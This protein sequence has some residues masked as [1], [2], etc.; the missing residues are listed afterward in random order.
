MTVITL[1][2]AA[3]AIATIAS[4]LSTHTQAA[5]GRTPGTHSVSP[6][7]AATYQIPLWL[8]PGAGGVQ[9]SLTIAYDSQ[10]GGGIVGPGWSLTGLSAITRCNKTFAQ[11]PLPS[12]V[13]LTYDD[14]F[15]LDGQRLRLTSGG[16]LGSYGQP[17]T[18]YDTE[19]ATFSLVTALGASGNGPE[20]FEVRGKNG[21]TYEFGNSADSR[22]TPS[23]S[24]ATIYMWLVNRVE[25]RFGNSYVVTYGTGAAGSAGIG[26]P[27][28]ISYSPTSAGASTHINSVIFEYGPKAG[29]VPGTTDPAIVGYVDGTQI[30]NTNLLLAVNANSNG[31][32]M[33]RYVMAY[34]AA[35]ATTRARLASVTECAGAGGSD[36]LAPTTVTYHNGASG[37]AASSPLALS[38]HRVIGR[39]DIN[40][41]GREDLILEELQ[42]GTSVPINL[43]VAF[44]TSTGFTSPITV[45]PTRPWTTA[46]GDFTGR[47]TNDFVVVDNGNIRYSWNG[48]QF[49][50]SSI[51]L[52]TGNHNYGV[53]IADVTGDGRDDLLFDYQPVKNGS[54]FTSLYASTSTSGGV[55]FDAPIPFGNGAGGVTG[56]MN[57]QS[58]MLDFDG[59]GREDWLRMWTT[60]NPFRRFVA[61]V[62]SRTT[63][64]ESSGSKEIAGLGYI[65]GYAR[66]NDD[67]CTDVIA[68]QA[69]Y[70]S[71]CNG[72]EPFTVGI[73]GTAR[74]AVDWNS[75]GRTDLLVE[76]G[77]NF[78]VLLSTGT[79]FAPMLPTSIPVSTQS[80]TNVFV[81]DMDGDGQHD[82]GTWDSS[83]VQLYK[84]ASAGIPPDLV[85]SITDGYGVSVSFAYASNADRTETQYPSVTYPERDYRG[86]LIMVSSVTTTSGAS[87]GSAATYARTFSY[88]GARTDVTGRGFLGF[89]QIRTT[90]SRNS[91]VRDVY[92]RTAFPFSGMV[93]QDDVLQSSSGLTIS[94]STFGQGLNDLDVSTSNRRVFVFT[95]TAN[96]TVHEVGGSLNGAVVKTTAQT[97][98]YDSFGNATNIATTVTDSQSGSPQF[99]Q[100]WTSTVAHTI[101]PNTSNWCLALPS[102]TTVTNTAPGTPALT[103]TTSFAIDYPTCRVTQETLEPGNAQ[104]QISR[105]VGFDGYGNVDT[106][107][108]TPIGQPPRTT[109]IVWA[110]FAGRFPNSVTQYVS[111][112]VSHTTT[113]GWD[114]ARGVRTSVTDPNTLQTLWDYDSFGRITGETRPDG[115][116]T[117]Y[118]LTS[119]DSSN[120]FCGSSTLRSSVATTLRNPSDTV[121]RTDSVYLDLFDRPQRTLGQLLS[122]A[123]S[124]VTR[125]YDVF[126]R[127][128]AES[129]P[130]IAGE[131]SPVTAYTYDLVGRVTRVRRPTSAAD[132]SNHDAL[133]DYLGLSVVQTDALSRTTT[134]RRNAVSLVTQAIDAAGSDTDYEYDAFGRLLKTRDVLGNEIVLTYN[135]RG[136][137]MTSIDPDMGSWQYDYFASGELES[138]TD[139]KA[140]TVS[141]TYDF[142]SRPLTRLEA[143][144]TTTWTWGINSANRNIGQLTRIAGPG[145]SEDY[146]Y[147][148]LGRL[149]NRRIDSDTTYNYDYTYDA[150]TG[151]LNTIE[152]PVS[153]S[154]YRLEL[155]YVYQNAL[156]RQ[157]RDANAS[158][159]FWEANTVNPLGQVTQETLGN[160]VVTNRFFDLVTGRL[161]SIQSGV[162][163]GAGLQNE[164]Y[165]FDRVGNLI[166]RQQN[167][168]GLTENFYYDALYRLD[169]STLG[170]TTN[171]DLAYDA[172][173]NITSRS[174]VGAGAT[175]TYHATK[176]H[177]VVQAG[178][179]TYGYDANGNAEVRNGYGITWTTYN[180]PSVINGPGKTL[181]FDYGPDRQR[182]R[183]VYQNGSVTETTM[184]IGG[185]LEKVTVGTLTDFRHYISGPDG[186]VAIVSR[187]T[188]GANTTRYILKDHLGSVARILN[189]NGTAFVSESFEAFG[190]RRDA[191]TWTGPCPC[192]TLSQIASV[193]RRGFTGHEMIGGHSMGL[194]HMNGRVFDSKI[195]RFLSAD[196][197]VQDPFRSQSFNR[198]TYASNNPLLFTD[199]TGFYDGIDR[200]HARQFIIL[201]WF[202]TARLW[203]RENWQPRPDLWTLRRDFTLPPYVEPPPP[204]QPRP[205]RPP[206]PPQ[207]STVPDGTTWP[208][209]FIGPSVQ[210]G[211]DLNGTSGTNPFTGFAEPGSFAASAGYEFYSDPDISDQTKTN[212]AAIGMFVMTAGTAINVVPL[213][214]VP[215]GFGLDVQGLGDG[216]PMGR[217]G[218]MRPGPLP[219]KIAET[220]RSSSY[221]A[222]T[223]TE[224]TTLYRAYGGKA[225]ATSIYW[226]RTPP[227][228]PIQATIDSALH[229]SFGNTAQNVSRIR[230]PAGTTIYEGVAAAQ[231]GLVG[232]GNQV[233][234]LN[235]N[236]AW[237]A[238]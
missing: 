11:D 156:L 42:S 194:I 54:W 196:P 172:I 86:P 102:Q 152:Y 108:V 158:T 157:V 62:L 170:G 214:A 218:P 160:G 178:S 198:Y 155:Q 209:S 27:I 140:Q 161:S 84:H 217:F 65:V 24:V 151:A 180:Y 12:N 225:Q 14:A 115:T 43:R 37:V 237:L 46:V 16:G 188:D 153:T 177:A 31:T 100:Q 74:A 85:A 71:G 192:P 107:T 137:K 236:P 147:D 187:R 92:M 184:Y 144:G 51:S 1:R 176:K 83:G 205:P 233:V 30:V 126:G 132:P 173:G 197:F 168:L 116:R 68:A 63:F 189:S 181:T 206:R 228:G 211:A 26:V 41:D 76:N 208:G 202:D 183:Q 61:V 128:S 226:T 36:C 169:Y 66:V 21:W 9:P 77:A 146:T 97:A 79:T 19:S 165:L 2:T 227:A 103:R 44:A 203:R 104:W 185:A 216:M 121:L 230:V 28:S 32:L 90:D 171:L 110:T 23:A 58:E 75:D 129:F 221:T 8:P 136:M 238:Q 167:Q 163:G 182:Y 98:T 33:R 13:T 29:Q 220:F 35:P 6:T 38:D 133:F 88:Y 199:P 175:W 204:T 148:S 125:T 3:I 135:V 81:I 166:Q 99:G 64:V 149:S 159:I 39:K 164:S 48:S 162:G 25:D 224:A 78:G 150:A 215:L 18:T 49:V 195:G 123:N 111:S 223:L 7:G 131:T 87:D 109:Q 55:T 118:S 40:G 139:A 213:A 145:Y 52:P 67:A 10:G 89:T 82:V 22:I 57:A 124:E 142:L 113:I 72:Q 56:S 114:A 5:V 210:A 134:Q 207:P 112:T 212:V 106:I 15:C 94:H 231:G 59:D 20:S 101:S 130:R 47:G 105:A 141:F 117:A 93:Y 119:C 234:I 96:H 91:I 17:A 80:A 200:P 229:W 179:N 186:T 190:G 235:V 174:D 50:S 138:Q 122:G 120:S 222:T 191:D 219:A 70:L 53:R 127:L 45:H 4:A 60:S 154:G 201:E 34:Q 232:G 143:E 69:I 73:S 193:S 95:N